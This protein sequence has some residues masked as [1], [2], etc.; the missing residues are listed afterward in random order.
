MAKQIGCSNH[1]MVSLL[2]TASWRDSD[3]TY[4]NETLF[5]NQQALECPNPELMHLQLL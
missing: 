1:K 5:L 2:Q 4:H 3:H